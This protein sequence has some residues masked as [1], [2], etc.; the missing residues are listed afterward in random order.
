M[1][2]EILKN[3]R[4]LPCLNL[5]DELLGGIG[6]ADDVAVHRLND[7]QALIATTDFFMPM[8]DEPHDFGRI[9]VTNVTQRHPTSPTPSATCTP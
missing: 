3:S 7:K 6:T 9:A 1:L 8:V 4:N 2:S 5:P